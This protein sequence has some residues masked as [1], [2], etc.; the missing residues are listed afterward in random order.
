MRLDPVPRRLRRLVVAAAGAALAAVPTA[1]GAAE[2]LV[3]RGPDGSVRIS[4]L[5]PVIDRPAV[6][7][8]LAS[9]LT[10]SFVLELREPGLLGATVGAARVD[11][12][13]ELWD[14]EYLVTAAGADGGR[15]HLR[16]A[17]LSAL[18][19]WW[20]RPEL[21]FAPSAAGLGDRL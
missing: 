8:Q 20:R 16:F 14:E 1:A 21:V 17:D 6:R 2:P 3:A 4:A 10:T 19:A 12:R 5:P 15:R 11:V 18:A 7:E 13:Y 9:G